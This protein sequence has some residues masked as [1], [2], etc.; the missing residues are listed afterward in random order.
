[1]NLLSLNSETL[2]ILTKFCNQKPSKY[3]HLVKIYN[4]TVKK[5]KKYGFSNRNQG[6]QI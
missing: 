6:G 1:M 3:K 5:V 4:E 2:M